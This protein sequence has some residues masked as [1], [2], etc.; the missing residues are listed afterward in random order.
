MRRATLPVAALAAPLALLACDRDVAPPAALDVPRGPC[1]H[2][3]YVL[4]T[5]Y[6]STELGVIGF[7][8]AVLAKGFV[9]DAS[10]TTGLSAPLAGDVVA[11]TTP[12]TSGDIVL[13]GRTP[14]GVITW[15]DP[16]GERP[17]RQLAVGA[18]T[19]P[20][21][22]AE[23]TATKA[24]VPRGDVNDD[25]ETPFERGGDV[26]VVDTVA[27]E[28]TA[29]I[30]VVGEVAKVVPGFVA[31]PERIIALGGAAF[32]V[33]PTYGPGFKTSGDSVLVRIDATTD[34]ITDVLVLP[35]MRGCL[36][37]S[38]SPD[39]SRIAV[40]CSGTFGGGSNPT[41]DDG[42][43]AIVD[44]ATRSVASTIPA[45]AIGRPP[46]LAI[47]WSSN[48]RLLVPVLGSID[49][50][51]DDALVE[52]ALA[53]PDA[54]VVAL[55]GAEAFTLGEVRCAPACGA[56]FLATKAAV[57]RFPLDATGALGAPTSSDP[58]TPRA[59][60]VLAPKFIGVY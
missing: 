54:P 53:S 45:T 10:A 21:D 22:Y 44:V 17:V 41:L 1:G 25:A 29:S 57:L 37:L 4:G 58:R 5:D 47:A 31:H 52:I 34:A 55:D 42:G 26:I 35:G 2:A 23:V 15:I 50:G 32:L 56:C 33:A 60:G 36:G 9:S 12:T 43:V 16:L 28:M 59:E 18:K 30:D 39:G 24:Y 6:Q 7:D 46:A 48:E 8:G 3:L 49:L 27:R 19:N 20:K 38:P 40:A 11:P 13:I 14:A 51:T